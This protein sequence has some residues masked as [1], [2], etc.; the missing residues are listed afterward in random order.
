M[1]DQQEIDV[2]FDKYLIMF[3]FKKLELSNLKD[4]PKMNLSTTLTKLWLV[5]T[6]S[7]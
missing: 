2:W 6:E 7:E 4:Q 1:I 5:K 3:V